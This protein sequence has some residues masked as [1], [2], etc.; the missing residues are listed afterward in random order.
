MFQGAAT[1]A[2]CAT[3]ALFWT[4]AQPQSV[5]RARLAPRE[6]AGERLT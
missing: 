1:P 5:P 3:R 6:P 2:V 4:V